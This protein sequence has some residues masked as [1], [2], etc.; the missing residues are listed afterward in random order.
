MEIKT[1][2]SEGISHFSYAVVGS[3]AIAVIDPSRDAE[4][5]LPLQKEFS[6]PIKYVLVTHCHADFV[7]GHVRLAEL[8]GATIICGRGTSPG[9]TAVEVEEG[10]EIDLGDILLKVIETPGHTPEHVSFVLYE[11]EYGGKTPFAVFSGDSLFSGDVGRPDLFGKE[12]QKELIEALFGT[13][14][15]YKAMPEHV[16]IYP[17]HGAGSFCGKRL[18]QRCPTTLGYEKMFNKALGAQSPE[19][20]EKVVLSNMPTPPPYYFQV[21]KRNRTGAGLKDPQKE[22][23][24][25]PLKEAL[26]S[27]ATLVD[28]RDQACFATAFIPGSINIASDIHFAMNT[29]M[30]LD[31]QQEII[32]LGDTPHKVALTL[33][34][35]GYDGLKGYI[36]GGYETYRNASLP[37]DSFPLISP[38]DALELWKSQS[39]LFVDVRTEGEFQEEHIKNA[40]SLP[41]PRLKEEASNL[42][43]DRTIICYCGHGCRGSLAASILKKLG[44]TNVANLAGGIIAWKARGLP[45][46]NT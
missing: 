19:E 26:S 45:V 42:P 8:T 39:A 21:S 17:A 7:G 22:L 34:R 18:S 9:Y 37:A 38:K 1:F 30:T 40:Q 46:D 15:K 13:L 44:F 2:Y 11:K 33:Y 36:T 16:L 41:L 32:L 27:K 29:G 24:A 20:L 3:S 10:Y 23:R 28:T 6:L 35:M 14:E 43:T 4:R 25:I 5:Y 31:A 12:K